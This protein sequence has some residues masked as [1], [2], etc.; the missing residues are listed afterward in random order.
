MQTPLDVQSMAKQA[1]SEIGAVLERVPTE[2][3]R[4]MCDTIMAAR[5]I[6]TYGVGREG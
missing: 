2:T 1:L 6:A 3:A 4:L 5:R